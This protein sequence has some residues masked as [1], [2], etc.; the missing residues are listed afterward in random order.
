[1]TVDYHKL[2]QVVT[3]IEAA[4]PGM[5]SLLEQMNTS[6]GAKYAAIDMANAFSLISIRKDH[7]K[8]FAFGWKGQSYIL[9]HGYVSSPALCRNLVSRSLIAFPFH[10]IS[11][12]FM[13]L[14]ILC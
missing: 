5:V 3:I 14:I 6:I 13:T 2:N 11:H 7:E 10:K 1:M 4:I 8:Q 9:P 12:W